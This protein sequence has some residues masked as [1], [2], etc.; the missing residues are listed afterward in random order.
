MHLA[1]PPEA[2]VD[3]ARALF[4]AFTLA[5]PQPWGRSRSPRAAQRYE[6]TTSTAGHYGH[7][8]VASTLASCLHNSAIRYA[9]LLHAPSTDRRWRFVA[10]P[11]GHLQPPGLFLPLGRSKRVPSRRWGRPHVVHVYSR[12]SFGA[13]VFSLVYMECC[14][15]SRAPLTFLYQHGRFLTSRNPEAPSI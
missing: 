6:G 9:P 2:C 14:S 11:N 12:W 15:C 5:R 8:P 13:A 1:E 4:R 7:V 3:S 10:Q